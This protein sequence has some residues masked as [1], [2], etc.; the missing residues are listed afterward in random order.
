MTR[1]YMSH[2]LAS[3]SEDFDYLDLKNKS[4]LRFI[5][6]LEMKQRMN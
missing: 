2:R 3:H 1:Q 6:I 4:S 5:E